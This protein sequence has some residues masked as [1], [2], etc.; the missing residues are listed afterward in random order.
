MNFKYLTTISFQLSIAS[1]LALCTTASAEW[2]VD[3]DKT[4]GIA[5]AAKVVLKPQVELLGAYDDRVKLSSG[6]K[7]EGDF[8]SD[9]AVAAE[10][11]NHPAVYNWWLKGRYGYRGYAEETDLNNDF[12]TVAGRLETK[13]APLIW[14]ASAD[15]SK[16]L[17]Y[18][19]QYNA[20]TGQGPDS[21]LTYQA[22][23]RFRADAD[24]S[25][26]KKWFGKTSLVPGYNLSYYHQEYDEN[27]I[28]T[29]WV[30]HRA[31]LLLRQQYSSKTRIAVGGIGEVQLNDS[32]TGN[33]GTLMIGV[34][35]RMSKKT[36]WLAQLGY[37]VAYYEISGTD[38]GMVSRLK[39]NWAYTKKVDFYVF[40]GNQFQPGYNGGGARM[41]YR[42]GYGGTWK[43][44]KKFSFSGAV[45][46]D[47]QQ[48][49]GEQQ[50]TSSQY[51]T[52]QHFI[53][54]KADYRPV[55]SLSLIAGIRYNYD[56]RPEPQ[57]KLYVS[58]IYRFN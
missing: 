15:L 4:D 54:L 23:T 48:Q 24:V 10:L 18:S 53:D 5:L 56:Y 21:V 33:I 9:I 44:V 27:P 14:Y 22:N 47:Y 17:D 39:G 49:I 7:A 58:A 42:L 46:H 43:V 34:E 30:I 20:D 26:D 1:L 32:E 25:Y 55:D 37:A 19:T 6:G 12:Y 38:Q 57:R 8:Y 3:F 28:R 16:S 40:G 29:E 11:L 31:R 45:L 2:V 51:G 36:L 41:V 52:V 13:K 50:S 35:H